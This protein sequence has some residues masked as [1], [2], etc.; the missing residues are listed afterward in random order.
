V[1]SLAIIPN[2]FCFTD[3]RPLSAVAFASLRFSLL[4]KY[5][6]PLT[7]IETFSIR[8]PLIFVDSF[9]MIPILAEVLMISV[10]YVLIFS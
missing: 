4:Q 3:L 9:A 6:V 10:T 2:A 8:L 5:D 1:R 7:I